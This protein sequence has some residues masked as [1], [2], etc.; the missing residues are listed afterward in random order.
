MPQAL[1]TY[2]TALSLEM[3]LLGPDS[4]TVAETLNNIAVLHDDRHDRR[5]AI[6][7]YE[8]FLSIERA[9]PGSTMEKAAEGARV[10]LQVLR[11]RR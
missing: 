6:A 2:Q 8:R 11:G 7:Y 5:E 10:R 3:E 4:P 9:L 1:E